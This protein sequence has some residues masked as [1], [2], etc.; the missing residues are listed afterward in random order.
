M[1]LNHTILEAFDGPQIQGHVAVTSRYQWNAIP[2]EH[3]GHTDDELVDRHHE[4]S[5]E[6]SSDRVSLI[7]KIGTRTVVTRSLPLSVLTSSSN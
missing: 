7:R 1:Q 4:V 6:S 3:W 5:T 2:N